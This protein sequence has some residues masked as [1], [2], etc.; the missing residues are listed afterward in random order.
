MKRAI[1]KARFDA[2]SIEGEQLTVKI[3]IRAPS[4]TPNPP[5]V[6]GAAK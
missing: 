3:A 5:A 1:V 4:R 6:T 2:I